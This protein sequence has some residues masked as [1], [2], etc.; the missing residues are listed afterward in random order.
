MYRCASRSHRRTRSLL[1]S[2]G[3]MVTFD[4]LCMRDIWR[5][6]GTRP[7][8][9]GKRRARAVVILIALGF[10][11]V[12][13]WCIRV[14]DRCGVRVRTGVP[15]GACAIETRKDK[16]RVYVFY[17]I[18]LYYSTGD[19]DS[20]RTKYH[21]T[22]ASDPRPPAR[23]PLKFENFIVIRSRADV[24]QRRRRPPRLQWISID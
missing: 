3:D 15:S 12:G 24:R 7:Q 8:I 1:R 9:S 18:L 4:T 20:R 11:I 10:R 16:S 14:V 2:Q 17:T 23:P 6:P 5:Y 22:A 19:G 13:S 21:D